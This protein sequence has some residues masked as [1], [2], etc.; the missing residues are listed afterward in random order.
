MAINLIRNI[1][2][3]IDTVV[4]D[5]EIPL[6]KVIKKYF[7]NSKY[8]IIYKLSQITNIILRRF[9]LILVGLCAY[10]TLVMMICDTC[11]KKY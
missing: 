3:N 5:T 9:A 8:K 1:D 10:W 2:I 4:T 7:P 11:W 6:N